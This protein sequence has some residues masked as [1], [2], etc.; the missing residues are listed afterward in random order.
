MEW[1]PIN[2]GG[3]EITSITYEDLRQLPTLVP[4][5][6]A[7]TVWDSRSIAQ[8][9][10]RERAYH[11]IHFRPEPGA[12][13]YNP[14]DPRLSEASPQMKSVF[15]LTLQQ[16]RFFSDDDVKSGARVAVI[17]P[18]VHAALGGGDVIGEGVTLELFGADGKETTEYFT[19]IGVLDHRLP[20]FDAL[21]FSRSEVMQS[22]VVE[23]L[24]AC[25]F[26]VTMDDQASVATAQAVQREQLALA[27]TVFNR[28]VIVPF[29]KD[30]QEPLA[31]S[32]P[33]IYFTVDIPE[34]ALGQLVHDEASFSYFPRGI[35]AIND[36]IRAA[37]LPRIGPDFNLLFLHQGTF[38]DYLRV[39]ARPALW[40]LGWIVAA[41]LFLVLLLAMCGWLLPVLLGRPP[42]WSV[43]DLYKPKPAPLP[44]L[45][46]SGQ[47]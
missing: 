4:A 30:K 41:G 42:L 14:P 36:R 38:A 39:H 7:V 1:R 37:L 26:R 40:I 33:L 15:G 3:T 46:L 23:R 27:N 13:I 8:I 34:E 47:C 12:V 24:V 17:G 25:L 11:D 28:S 18:N 43:V 22:E 29:N 20:L 5:V 32:P 16:G 31:T 35:A 2:P 9:Y 19:V 10:L 6:T 45:S 44:C 21:L